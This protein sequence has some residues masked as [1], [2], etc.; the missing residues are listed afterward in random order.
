MVGLRVRVMPNL[1]VVD[2]FATL[3]SRPAA[4]AFADAQAAF[5]AGAL[6]GQEAAPSTLAATRIAAIGQK[7]V[8]R[9][10]GLADV[11][12]F[13]VRRATW[14]A[15]N[16]GQRTVVRSAAN[17]A[18]KEAAALAREEAALAELTKQ[19]VTIVR[20]SAAQRV[21]FRA[22]CNPC[23]TSGRR[24]SAKSWC[25]RQKPLWPASPPNNRSVDHDPRHPRARCVGCRLAVTKRP[26]RTAVSPFLGR[27]VGMISTQS[28]WGV[29][30]WSHRPSQQIPPLGMTAS[31]VA[32]CSNANSSVV[33]VTI[34][35]TS[36]ARC[37][38]K[39][40]NQMPVEECGVQMPK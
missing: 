13:A 8:T 10:G 30:R 9:W 19:G 4:M 3:G 36:I 6:D 14:D 5:L 15:W 24:R 21:A 29:R 40:S 25:A 26:M 2:T 37:G 17:E 22:A 39:P 11:M 1:L 12:V 28:S 34:S 32:G 20:S 7:Y 27:R 33:M 16:D 18:A 31:P 23:G 38:G 35:V